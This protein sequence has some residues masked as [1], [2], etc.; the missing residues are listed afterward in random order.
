[1]A[2]TTVAMLEALLDA[3]NRHDL[4]AVLRHEAGDGPLGDDD[5][6]VEEFPM[7]AGGHPT[8]DSPWPSS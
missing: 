5:A 2:P 3:F 7:D 8:G 6:E 4:E 1:M